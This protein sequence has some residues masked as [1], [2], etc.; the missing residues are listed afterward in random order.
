MSL[1]RRALPL[2]GALALPGL[3]R[4]QAAFPNRPP[5]IL[6]PFTP[7][8]SPDIVS[9]MLAEESARRWPYAIVVENR[10]GAGGNIAAEAVA[11]AAPDGHTLL[12]MT[13]NI[14]AVNPFVSRMPIDPLTDLVPVALLARSPLVILVPPESP[15]RD[16]AGL[17]AAARAEPGRIAYASAGVGSPHHLAMALLARRANIEMTHVPYRGTAPGLTDLVGGRV[18]AM[19]SPVG[20]ALPLIQDGRLRPLAAAGSTRL[21]WLPHVP[22]VAEAALPGYDANTWLSLAAPRG[23]P[24]PV[25]AALLEL[26]E[27]TI[28]NPRNRELLD[29]QGI[30]A[31]FAGPDVLRALAR[32]DHEIWGQVI[33]EAGITAE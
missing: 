30:V 3:A 10:P 14:V 11:R 26:S 31:E 9:R 32:S 13:N 16:I 25:L 15:I 6:V 27:A 21:P 22:T 4:A 33:R 7:G 12:L 23:T 1:P 17:I 19:A 2:L 28:N 20:T 18:A 29:R 5:R 24:Q 8:G